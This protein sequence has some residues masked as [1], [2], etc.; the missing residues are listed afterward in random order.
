MVFP[1]VFSFPVNILYYTHPSI[2]TATTA[3]DLASYGSERTEVTLSFLLL[4]FLLANASPSVHPLV[5]GTI[6]V[7]ANLAGP[8]LSSFILIYFFIRLFV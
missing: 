6:S 8:I 3:S 1:G 7:K 2:A 5:Q 4:S